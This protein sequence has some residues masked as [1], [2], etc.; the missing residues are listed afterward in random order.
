MEKIFD[1]I[2]VLFV[3]SFL[4]ITEELLN[5]NLHLYEQMQTFDLSKLD[6]KII[7]ENIISQYES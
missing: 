3:N 6:M 4:D 7:Y 5:D 1:G 2:P